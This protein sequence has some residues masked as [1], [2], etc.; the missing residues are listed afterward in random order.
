MTRLRAELPLQ[1]TLTLDGLRVSWCCRIVWGGGG[2]AR[3]GAV[4]CS[5]KVTTSNQ[6]VRNEHRRQYIHTFT[7]Y[8]FKEMMNLMIRK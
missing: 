2:T 7:V 1:G 8:R 3:M 6:T 5:E 4:Y